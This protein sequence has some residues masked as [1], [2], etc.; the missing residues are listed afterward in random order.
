M[1]T[2]DRIT[3]PPS[4]DPAAHVG[5]DFTYQAADD[6]MWS[7]EAAEWDREYRA[8]EEEAREWAKGH[9]DRSD[10]V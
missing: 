6:E 9:A 7:P 1:I 3:T 4:N 2:I 8:A 10:L 5:Y